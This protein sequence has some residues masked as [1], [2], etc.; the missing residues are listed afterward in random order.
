MAK[1]WCEP[2]I[3]PDTV[4]LPEIIPTRLRLED[5]KIYGR[6]YYLLEEVMW[7]RC[8]QGTIPFHCFEIH[9]KWL[10]H[11]SLEEKAC[12]FSA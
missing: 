5:I 4:H 12:V 6:Q 2:N 7:Y 10:F 9:M 1:L 11:R 3:Y 8:G